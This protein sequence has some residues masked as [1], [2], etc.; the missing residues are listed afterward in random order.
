MDKQQTIESLAKHIANYNKEP[1][2]IY[3]LQ[4]ENLYEWVE[5]DRKRIVEPL[6]K[7]G[8]ITYG[9][10]R[11]MPSYESLCCSIEETIKL[12]GLTD[13]CC[14]IAQRRLA[15]EFKEPMCMCARCVKW[16]MNCKTYQKAQRRKLKE[17]KKNQSGE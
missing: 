9:P 5:A 13:E 7:I 15:Q 6:V 4:A 16:R 17:L 2:E 12:A 3:L 8:K 1:V 11:N 14:E 10:P